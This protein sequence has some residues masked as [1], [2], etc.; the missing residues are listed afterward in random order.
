MQSAISGVMQ[1]DALGGGILEIPH[2]QGDASSLTSSLSFGVKSLSSAA[3]GHAVLTASVV[4]LIPDGAYKHQDTLTD[5][6]VLQTGE[7]FRQF[8]AFIRS[9]KAM[10]YFFGLGF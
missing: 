3:L 2:S 4:I 6:C 8:N 10:H 7:G 1:A 9:Q 5:F